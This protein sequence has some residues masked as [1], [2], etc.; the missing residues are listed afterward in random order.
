MRVGPASRAGHGSALFEGR[1]SECLLD[2]P[3]GPVTGPPASRDGPLNACWTGLPGR[4]PV[5]PPERRQVAVAEPALGWIVGAPADPQRLAQ[6]PLG[7]GR[8]DQVGVSRV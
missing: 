3:P 2:R 6:A 4:S 1:P 7:E 8:L 5:H